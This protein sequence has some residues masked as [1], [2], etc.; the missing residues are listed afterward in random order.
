MDVTD[1][2]VAG[3]A[4]DHASDAVPVD[5]GGV[6]G[7]ESSGAWD[8]GGVGGLPVGDQVDEFGVEGD[9]AVVAEFAD[10]DV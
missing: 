5:V 4:S 2:G 1:A 6:V 9:V 3:D 7:E 10:G 8:V